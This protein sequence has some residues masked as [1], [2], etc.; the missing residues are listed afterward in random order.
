MCMTMGGGNGDMAAAPDPEAL[1]MMEGDERNVLNMPS[2][3]QNDPIG[4]RDG[5]NDAEEAAEGR[6]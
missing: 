4:M 2:A 6:I 1:I 3:E 5:D